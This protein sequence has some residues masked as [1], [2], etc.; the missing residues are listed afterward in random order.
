MTAKFLESDHPFFSPERRLI[1]A[2]AHISELDREIRRFF[3]SRPHSVVVEH[4]PDGLHEI[5]KIKPTKPIPLDWSDIAFDALVNLRS[6][7]DQ[8]GYA[9]AA[10]SGS[11]SPTRAAFIVRNSE[12]EFEKA[13]VKGKLCSDIPPE[14]VAI[15]RGLKPYKTGDN[16]I[17]A[18]NKLR[19]S[20]H[21]RLIAVDASMSHVMVK[22]DPPQMPLGIRAK[23]DSSKNEIV[24]ARGPRGHRWNCGVQPSFVVGFDEI[25]VTGRT[26]AVAQLNSMADQV[27][28]TL[29]AAYDECTR[30]GFI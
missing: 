11:V 26:Q 28:R 2:Y 14:V 21:T 29:R 9:A 17:W 23:W 13:I 8:I 4:D 24:F 1:R 22:H 25:S 5:H 6:A 12:T 7:L 27:T 30:L 20:A 10:A 15:F 18:L 16:A 19:N 3:D